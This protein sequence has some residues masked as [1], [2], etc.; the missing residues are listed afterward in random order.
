MSL[1]IYKLTYIPTGKIYIGQSRN[2]EGRLF[3]HR[4]D[5]ERGCHH[6]KILQADFDK[7]G[8]DLMLEVLENLSTNNRKT[9]SD[10]EFEWMKRTKS[11]NDFIGYNCND[12]R[13]RNTKTH[14]FTQKMQEYLEI[15]GEV[16]TDD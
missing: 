5:L 4:F 9:A 16:S 8:G 3:S 2:P 13:V 7:Y 11:Y 12:P 1:C 15:T 14:R 10:K 6:N